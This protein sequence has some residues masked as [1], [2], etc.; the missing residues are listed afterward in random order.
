M[1][2]SWEKRATEA[3][4]ASM[5][6]P[7]WPETR[8]MFA[9]L[10]GAAAAREIAAELERA[11][12]EARS[13]GAS[14][15]EELQ[16]EWRSRLRRL[17]A[18]DPTAAE[19]LGAFVTEVAARGAGA[20]S[21]TLLGDVPGTVIQIGSVVGSVGVSGGERGT[22][23]GKRAAKRDA[24]RWT[25]RGPLVAAGVGVTV[26]AVA[27]IG[28]L[29]LPD[30]SAPAGESLSTE[31]GEGAVA[32]PA[33]ASRPQGDQVRC[34][35]PWVEKDA[36]VL[37]RPCIAPDDDGLRLSVEVQ[38]IDPTEDTTE[39][40]AWVWLMR[41]DRELVQ[42]FGR[43]GRWDLSR[44][45]D[46]LKPCSLTVTGAEIATCGP[47]VMTPT[48]PGRY[49]ASSSVHLLQTGPFPPGWENPEFSGTQSPPLEWDGEGGAP[50]P[51]S[52]TSAAVRAATARRTATPSPG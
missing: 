12:A 51:E 44:D 21:N 1:A 35:E 52:T 49:S 30:R 23:A 9:G 48:E 38:L 10:F 45:D 28:F 40:S 34:H 33:V 5:P 29:A 7:D 18:A 42:E 27:A 22:E 43:S 20:T 11:R 39:V 19:R 15:A 14:V 24:A 50:L 47:F 6:T 41:S 2:A 31:S 37:Y 26:F 36:S 13:G 4:V 17:V 32:P 25:G 3:L 8:D 16:V 46:L